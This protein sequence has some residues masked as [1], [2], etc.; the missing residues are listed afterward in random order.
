MACPAPPP[1][2]RMV[3]IPLGPTTASEDQAPEGLADGRHL[4]HVLRVSN[5]SE[6]WANA[7]G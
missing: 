1:P 7:G 3:A 2:L 5:P 4:G 6:R